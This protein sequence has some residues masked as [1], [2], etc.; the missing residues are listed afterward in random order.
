M[1]SSD[2]VL[3]LLDLPIRGSAVGAALELGL[4]WALADGPR[5]TESLGA[6]LA[7]PS[8]RCGSF[9][10]LLE[11]E[12]L[13]DATEQGWAL[14]SVT[15]SAIVGGYSME[16]WQ[17]LAQEA[18][19]RCATVLDLP[20]ALRAERAERPELAGYV[21]AMLRD[22]ERARRFTRML[23]EVH[24][25]LARQ[26]AAVLDLAG[27]RSLMDLGGGSGVVSLALARRWPELHATVVDVATVCAAGRE[28]AAEESLTDRVSYRPANFLADPLPGG[29][30]AI[31]E[32]DVA[33]YSVGLFR[34]VRE[35][36]AP[37]GRFFVV[38]AFA[39]DPNEPEPGQGFRC[40]AR[41]RAEVA[42]SLVRLLRDPAWEAPTVGGISGLL[43]AAGFATIEV[44]RLPAMPGVG[45][46]SEMPTVLEAR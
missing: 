26:L 13:L 41:R 38:D 17:F 24:Q 12:G 28:V 35:A 33:I 37:D 25:P 30:D 14:T 4:F 2:Q 44:T 3:D 5:K 40:D 1:T 34:K 45:G 43:M 7:I 9:L 39:V 32:C 27:V 20:A 42:W 31:I 46:V 15:R 11:S 8:A 18:R 29:F 19:E 21:E 22:L 16:T 23:F 6:A 10:A 36:L